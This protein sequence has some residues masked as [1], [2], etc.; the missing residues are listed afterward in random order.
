MK[1]R[2]NKTTKI[3]SLVLIGVLSLTLAFLVWRVA[4]RGEEIAPVDSS[5]AEGFCLDA[6][7]NLTFPLSK[8][9]VCG[10]GCF[11]DL[12]TCPPS[13]TFTINVPVAG[14][15]SLKGVVARGHKYTDDKWKGHKC[16]M[17]C[18]C[19]HYE[20]FY[21]SIG[22]KKGINPV[23]DDNTGNTHGD[24]S[25]C[26]I[27]PVTQVVQNLGVFNLDSGSNTVTMSTAAPRCPSETVP[28]SVQLVQ[29]CLYPLCGNGVVDPGEDCDPEATP[30]GCPSGYRC[31]DDCTCSAVVQDLE[32]DGEGKGWADGGMPSGEYNLDDDISFSAM[33]GDTDGV[34]KDSIQAS[35][36]GNIYSEVQN[37][38]II[39]NLTC[40]SNDGD[41]IISCSGSLS[42]STNRLDA[43][44]YRLTF[45]WA[46]INGNEGALCE[47]ATIFKV[48][49]EETNP[50]WDISKSVVEQCIED[51]TENP[52]ARLTYTITVDNTG[53]ASGEIS[54]VVDDLDGKVLAAGLVPASISPS[55]GSYSIGEI[56]WDYSSSPESVAAGSSKTFSYTL[57]VDKD[58]FGIY[59]NTVTLSP[60]GSSDIQASANIEADCN[61]VEPEPDGPVP[62]TGIF[63]TTIG[64]FVVGIL[65]VLFGVGIYRIPNRAL[66]G[67]EKEP[68]YRYRDRFEKRVDKK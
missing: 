42:S 23:K 10:D 60:V 40:G 26:S 17:K 39:E 47:L 45:S 9:F 56:E 36:C 34:D 37:C 32:C 51:S 11:D 1:F 4:D 7:P 30:P 53:D 24:C 27:C 14:T 2:L 20:E 50:N 68:K 33:A 63:D 65:L 35:L 3:V 61:I 38:S 58:N 31:L 22:G 21:I 25:D 15:Y 6:D 49:P 55:A 59:N 13:R 46:D 67:R 19:Q 16:Y 62:E 18:Q 64:R 5:A 41:P 52:V 43:T 44:D 66:M 8:M 48:L 12:D 54:K 57:D 28:D 29:V